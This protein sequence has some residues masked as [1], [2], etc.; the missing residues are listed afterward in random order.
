MNTYL[1][2]VWN[3]P[4]GESWNGVEN[5]EAP[6][7]VIARTCYQVDES[8]LPSAYSVRLRTGEARV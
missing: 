7:L 3:H 5:V 4:A 2:G 1:I 6:I 8:G